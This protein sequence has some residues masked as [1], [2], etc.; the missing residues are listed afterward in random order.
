VD[1]IEE[2]AGSNG[3]EEGAGG[4]GREAGAWIE[5]EVVWSVVLCSQ[6]LG[7]WYEVVCYDEWVQLRYLG[8]SCTGVCWVLLINFS[9]L[10]AEVLGIC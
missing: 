10:Q 7:H 6:Q 4:N 1:W 5:E 3:R 2:G 9:V 8:R